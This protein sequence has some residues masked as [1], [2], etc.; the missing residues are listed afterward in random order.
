M[1]TFKFLNPKAGYDEKCTKDS[2][3]AFRGRCKK[4]KL[5]KLRIEL[6]RNRFIQRVVNE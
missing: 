6:R 3:R 2:A 1:E 4:L 5:D